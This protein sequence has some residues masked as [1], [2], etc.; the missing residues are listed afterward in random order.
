MKNLQDMN[1]TEILKSPYMDATDDSI[2]FYVKQV[3]IELLS[4]STTLPW[5]AEYI[6]A[7][8]TQLNWE[9]LSSNPSLPWTHELLAKYFYYF[10]WAALSENTKVP[11]SSEQLY[12][13]QEYDLSLDPDSEG[14]NIDWGS[15]SKNENI[16]FEISL[17]KN[18]KDSLY[19]EV[20]LKNK[21]IKWT[22]E[23]LK[24]A[25]RELGIPLQEVKAEI[26]NLLGTK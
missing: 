3:A 13:L 7:N 20:L 14:E 23:M 8:Q 22:L 6:E 26:P 12:E 10:D 19:W 5:T 2:E 18:L 17:M 4:A 25:G 1:S 9:T 11:F 21:S 24:L 16:K 15:I